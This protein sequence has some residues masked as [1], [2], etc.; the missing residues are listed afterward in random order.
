MRACEAQLSR[1]GLT[2]RGALHLTWSMVPISDQ[3]RRGIIL[4]GPHLRVHLHR[5]RDQLPDAGVRCVTHQRSCR[6]GIRSSHRAVT[7]RPRCT[8][9]RLHTTERL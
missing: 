2:Q 1:V 5:L 4:L 7:L 3:E 8:D 9:Q 6:A